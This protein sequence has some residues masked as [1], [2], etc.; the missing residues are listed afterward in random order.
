MHIYGHT[1]F[2]YDHVNSSFKYNSKEMPSAV[3]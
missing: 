1:H 3:V 2:T